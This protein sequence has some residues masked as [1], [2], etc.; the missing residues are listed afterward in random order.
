MKNTNQHKGFTLI[1][2]LVVIAIIGV[3]ASIVLVALNGARQKSRDTKRVADMRQV[4]QALEIFNQD[5]GGYP[6]SPNDL[7]PAYTGTVPVAPTPPDGACTGSE[8]T[9]TYTPSG[10]SLVSE[11]DGTTTVYPDYA[12]TFC[13]GGSVSD[14]AAGTHTVTPSGI[15]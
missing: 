13:L 3:L 4:N 10:T 7:T 8:N 15:Q 6:T 1:E 14:F 11:K 12:L 5:Y 9:Y 2:L